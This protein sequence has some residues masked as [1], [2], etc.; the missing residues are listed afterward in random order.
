M[1][2]RDAAAEQLKANGFP[3][4]FFDG[5]NS[6]RHSSRARRAGKKLMGRHGRDGNLGGGQSFGCGPERDIPRLAGLRT[7][8]HQ[9]KSVERIAFVRLETIQ[10]WSHPRCQSP[11]FRRGR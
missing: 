4:A 2:L 3:F 7:D 11:R 6:K 5:K 10:N 9:T 1:L 8:Y